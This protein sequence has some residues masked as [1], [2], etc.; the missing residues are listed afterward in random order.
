MSSRTSGGWRLLLACL[1]VITVCTACGG[2]TAG[3]AAEPDG[4][5]RFPDQ[6]SMMLF[7]M[8]SGSFSIVDACSTSG[9]PEEITI[10][11]VTAE[12]SSGSSDIDFRVGWPTEQRPNRFGS[13]PIGKLPDLFETAQGSSGTAKACEDP[14]SS[15]HIAT[16]FPPAVTEDI[17]VDG[18][19]VTYEAAGDRYRGRV[20]V[21]LG[22]CASEPEDRASDQCS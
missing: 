10:I 3:R 16:L 15:L 19:V 6:L 4:P 9:Q 7:P 13:A 2:D 20:D 8:N 11:D 5:L 14:P 18:L 21:T 12:E 1:A 22:I 17:V